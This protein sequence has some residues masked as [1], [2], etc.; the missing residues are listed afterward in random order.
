MI[1]DFVNGHIDISRDREAFMLLLVSFDFIIS[2]LLSQAS[3]DI[4]SK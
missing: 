1:L 2:Y 4:I 3:R